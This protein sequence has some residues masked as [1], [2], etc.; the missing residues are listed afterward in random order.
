[1][2]VGRVVRAND[3]PKLIVRAVQRLLEIALRNILPVFKPVLDHIVVDVR[4]RIDEA[5]SRFRRMGFA[6]TA[7]GHH[8][9]GS[10][11]HLA[12]FSS[13]YLELLGWES[14]T[15]TQRPEL[16]RYP[17]GLNGLVFRAD[18][19][20]T[21]AAG[22]ANVGLP[23]LPPLSFARDVRLPNGAQMQAR[24]RTVSFDEGTFG[25]TRTYFCE[26]F[27]PELVYRPE[28]Q[29]HPN[30][31]TQITRVVIQAAHPHRIGTLFATMFG[32][33]ATRLE[34]ET[35]VLETAGVTIEVM[36]R[37]EVERAFGD[38]SADPGPRDEAPVAMTFASEDL[39]KT[40]EA[41]AAN[42][43]PVRRE[44]ERLI[45]AARDALNVTLE[46]VPQAPG[47]AP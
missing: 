32:E 2:I 30:G 35:C 38:A 23:T 24:F 9:L 34:G 46:F 43:I 28:W 19:V 33:A 36:Q 1:M 22:L 7:R 5:E 25:W 17:A 13:N 31:A 26:H 27:T 40:S 21:V 18:D 41:L 29:L 39:Q 15:K 10:S 12:I 42:G 37:S 45:V 3:V 47:A 14:G 16:V 20:D 44:S 6:L 8:T 4:D 11:N